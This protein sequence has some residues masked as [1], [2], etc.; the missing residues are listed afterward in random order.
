MQQPSPSCYIPL[1]RTA[2]QK[3]R[4]KKKLQADGEFF[5]IERKTSSFLIDI[6]CR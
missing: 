5:Y 2:E 4:E 3:K 1:D 6:V